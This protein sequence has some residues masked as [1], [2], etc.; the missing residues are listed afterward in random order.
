M[1]QHRLIFLLFNDVFFNFQITQN[2]M[3]EDFVD[4][5]SRKTWKEVL[6]AFHCNYHSTPLK[7]LRKIRT[8]LKIAG[9]LIKSRN[10]EPLHTKLER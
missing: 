1:L 5:E 4:D 3:A 6:A 7:G 9:L 2:Q 8:N 10:G